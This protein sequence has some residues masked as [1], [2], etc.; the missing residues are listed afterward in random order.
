MVAELSS[1]DNRRN[2]LWWFCHAVYCRR[3]MADPAHFG[4]DHLGHLLSDQLL[5]VPRFQRRYSWVEEHVSE[6]W[7]D[8]QRAAAAGDSYFMGTVVLANEGDGSTRKLIIDGQQRITTTA[9]LFIAL[10]DRL[11]ELDQDRPARAV[12]ESHL[13]D[14]I[15]AE[16]QTVAK[17]T[18]S[19]GDHPAFTA[20]L[21]RIVPSKATDLVSAAYLQLRRNI[22][23]LAPQTSDYRKLIE[24]VEYLDKRVQVLLAV[25]TGLPEA[26]VIFETLN[27]RGADLTT[28]DLLKNYLFSQAGAEGISYAEST[29][30]RIA[31]VL[32]KPDDFLRFLRHEYMS[33]KG[34]VTNRG[35][36]RALQAD[37]GQTPTGVRRY[38]EATDKALNRYTALREPDDASWS[39]QAIEVKDSLLA[40]R[41]FGFETS[42]P[43][44]LAAFSTWSHSNATRFVDVVANWSVRALIAGT[45]GGGVAE[46]RFCDAAVAIVSKKA[47]TSADVRPLLGDLVPDDTVFKEAFLGYGSVTTTRGKYLLARIERQYAIEKGESGEGVPDWSSKSV[48][49]EHIFAKSTKEDRFENREA[50]ERFALLRDQIANMTLLER[51]LNNALEDKPFEDKADTYGRSAFAITRLLGDRGCWTLDD[52]EHR[53]VF[54]ADLAVRAWPA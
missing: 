51:S 39:S 30:T 6:F 49:V 48:S 19:P 14:Y 11:R 54:L 15:L 20:L 44:L 33:R 45:L 37:I 41:R 28:A 47:K 9:I 46:S 31:A 43:L 13:S 22:N 53:S 52:A 50:F 16:E 42:M 25:A 17:L 29:W 38:L 32:E 8:I 40:F 1:A 21:D 24:L 26:Y 27:D 7:A 12:E 2:S 36:Y 34:H 3:L 5:K 10:R 35:L 4:H 18:L 23:E